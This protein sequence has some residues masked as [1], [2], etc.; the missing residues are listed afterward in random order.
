MIS[1]RHIPSQRASYRVSI[2]GHSC[3]VHCLNVLP[4]AESG[5]DALNVSAEGESAEGSGGE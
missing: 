5:E 2:L 4:Q 3:V 1:P